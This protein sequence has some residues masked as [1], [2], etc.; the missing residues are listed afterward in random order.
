MRSVRLPAAALLTLLAIEFIDELVGGVGSAAWPTVRSDPDLTYVHIG[1]LLSV[2]G[3]V[4]SFVEPFMCVLGDVGCRRLLVLGGGLAFGNVFG[5]AAGLIP[6]GLGVLS[7]KWGLDTAM[8]L[9]VAGPVLLLI[10]IARS[11]S[12][13]AARAA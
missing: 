7:A 8:W 2:P 3:N 12:D 9:L 4:A 11:A 1:L 5:P 13:R 6:L 10:G